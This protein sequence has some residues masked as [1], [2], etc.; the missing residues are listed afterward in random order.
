MTPVAIIDFDGTI[1]EHRFPEIGEPLPEAFE[2]LKELKEAGWKLILWTCREDDGYKIDRQ[3]LAAAVEFCR[4][5]G[6][7]FDAVNGPLKEHDFRPEH[8]LRRKPYGHCYI[9]DRNLGGFPGWNVVRKV[10]LEDCDVKLAW[11]EDNGE[12]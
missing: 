7:E 12:D 3:Y 6:V 11:L 1:V 8:T 9:D 10:L 2:V 5:N 4:E